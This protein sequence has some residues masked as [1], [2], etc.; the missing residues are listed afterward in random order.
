MDVL[1]LV[2]GPHAAIR[3]TQRLKA[4]GG[5]GSKLY[6][7]TFE[8]GVYVFESRRIGGNSVKCVLLDGVASAA[9]RQEEALAE[10]I[11]R[12]AIEL[13]HFVTDFSGIPEVGEVTT[14]TAP[15]RVFDAIFRDSELDGK[16]Y[17]KS[18]LAVE[19]SRA[20]T[21]NATALFEHAPSAL[22]FGAWDSTGAAGGLGNKFPRTIVTEI[23]GVNVERGE[24]RGGIRQDP[25]AVSRYVE[26]EID[27]NKDWKPKGLVDRS[28]KEKEDRAK[29]TRPSEV[30]HG[31]ILV[32]VEYENVGDVRYS[33]K[34]GITC[35]YA[36]QQS[37]ISLT[38]LRRLR[39][40]IGEDKKGNVKLDPKVDDAA[41][42]V[43]VAL[44]LV[45][46]TA[47]RDRGY[48]LR[49]RC[50]LVPDGIAPFEVLGHDGSAQE[51]MMSAATA[52]E[53]YQE[54]VKY[55]QKVGL[56]WEPKPTMMKPQP[57]LAKLVA[58]SRE[59]GAE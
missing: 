37:V 1:K 47:S 46:L 20:N 30:N 25:L 35:D 16:P 58:L 52:I 14:L 38:G 10:L 57:K 12:G 43:L 40:P 5:D 29:G 18:T 31:N 13:P 11:A 59:A 34:G 54:T 32:T 33:K 50:D 36:L 49:S 23:I 42:A 51:E 27:K 3:L 26:I 6:P 45:A 24:T 56:P 21:K 9:N 4:A 44:G 2:S 55:A 17:P 53:I 8:G 7:P 19:L 41:R 48:A 22:L 28:K 15:H 39:F